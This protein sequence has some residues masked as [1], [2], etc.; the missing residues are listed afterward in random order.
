MKIR[1][2]T[3]I[4]KMMAALLSAVLVVGMVQS[5]APMTALAQ[6][7]VRELN[8]KTAAKETG[9]FVCNLYLNNSAWSGQ[10]VTVQDEEGV[11]TQCIGVGGDVYKVSLPMETKY[12]LYVNGVATGNSFQISKFVGNYQI[13][14][15]LYS[16]SFKDS[17]GAD[18]GIPD[19]IVSRLISPKQPSEPVSKEDGVVFDKWL[20]AD[21]EEFDFASSIEDEIVLYASWKRVSGKGWELDADGKLTIRTHEGMKDWNINGKNIHKDVKSA[22]IQDGVTSISGSAFEDCVNLE[23]IDISGSVI[24]IDENAFEGCSSLGSIK[25]PENLQRIGSYAF[26]E[27]S[28]LQSIEIPENVNLIEN[29]AFANCANLSSVKFIVGNPLKIQ[30]YGIA[31]V[32]ENCK[33]VT[34]NKKGIHVPAGTVHDYQ[35]S[36]VG[37][38]K[39]ITDD[40][41]THDDVTC[42]AWRK[43]DSL[44]TTEGNYY[45]TEDVTLSESW[46][47][48]YGDGEIHLCLNGKTIRLV[49]SENIVRE[50]IHVVNGWTLN[51]H[52]CKGNGK[53]TG[54]TN[55][56]IQNQGIFTMYGGK[57]T[58]NRGS[59]S[60]VYNENV[61]SMY[62]GEISG[63]LSIT[64]N[65]GAVGTSRKK[66]LIVGGSA[67]IAENTN[68]SEE[69]ANLLINTPNKKIL[70]DSA[71]PLSGAAKISIRLYSEEGLISI[72]DANTKDYSRY[73]TS[74]DPDFD[75]VN[76]PDNEVQ[77]I[78][79]H[80]HTLKEH[81]AVPATCTEAGTGAYWKC[82]GED[83]CNQMFSDSTGNNEI[84]EIPEGD[85][86]TGHDYGAWKSNGDG[87]HTRTCANDGAHTE[88]GDCSGGTPTYTEKAV[89][90]VC[91]GSYG[92]VLGDTTPPAGTIRIDDNSWTD[93]LNTITF[94]LFF[95]ETKQVTIEA[96]DR[97]SGVDKIYYHISG[98]NLTEA[99]VKA[100]GGDDW[101]EG[102]S[103]S[104][105]PDRRC[106]IYAKITDKAGN[107]TYLSSDG[108][109]FDG[110]APVIIG[111]TDGETYTSSKVVYVHE[112]NLKSVT[113]NGTEVALHDSAFILK[114]NSGEQTIVATDKAGN[115]TT[116][117]VTMHTHDF[118]EK[119][120]HSKTAHWHE[121]AC[122]QKSDEAAHDFGA[123]ITDKEATESEAGEKHRVCQTCEFEEKETIPAI[124]GGDKPD[125]GKIEQ[126]VQKDDKAPDTKI[127]TPAEKML[128]IVLTPE[129]KEQLSKGTDIKIVL[130][131]KDVSDTVSSGD[132]ALAEAA[133]S[134]DGVA[135]GFAISQYL[136][137]SL[138]KIIGENRSA[139]SETKEKIALALAVP[140]S[141]KNTDSK[142]TRT[143]AVLRI[144]DGK[145]ELLNDVDDNA[146]TITIETDRFATYA[147]V[148]KDVSNGGSGDNNGNDNKDNQDVN[149]KNDNQDNTNNNQNG[150]NDNKDNPD[151]N[152]NDINDNEDDSSDDTDG[153]DDSD[154]SDDS[155]DSSSSG[156]SGSGSSNG[157]GPE[158]GD[159][160]PIE[161]YATLSM[162][163][164][165]TWLLL[166]FSDRKRGMTEETKKRLVSRIVAWAKRGSKIRK[167]PAIAVIVV[168]LV[169]YHSIGKKT[170]V[171]WEEICEE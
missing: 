19:Q 78:R 54:G 170:C 85:D 52:D 39:Y 88:D 147:I 2:G 171:E 57:I 137:I 29:G 16:V 99:G 26:V 59:Y 136:D 79:K 49:T 124:G 36:F 40:T 144:H 129:E 64:V 107:V 51:L 121:C 109:V 84:T 100:L 134:G 10:S 165:F 156:G 118:G 102:D 111:V 90:S 86:A 5:A 143:F 83:G 81:K 62:G 23:E 45:L 159:S 151:D 167:Y 48:F 11:S 68:M 50:V 146:D 127:A 161:F 32:F 130:D 154:S 114:A 35:N 82:E 132:K 149:N 115:T 106:V 93:F 131:V 101:T 153:D 105:N 119:W 140:D 9:E 76:G 3:L 103:F 74:D 142:K 92:E 38:E 67:V 152:K 6:E 104:I 53:I 33:F 46:E 60:G 150:V 69:P 164:G 20:T 75:V 47:P 13:E 166:Y 17:D 37:M 163:A 116:V 169:Y 96:E 77:L 108:L 63:N 98:Y 28:S 89:C 94:G 110:T 125:I 138:F 126:G 25:L 14:L 117:T 123:W 95:R 66:D 112:A 168:L 41:N 97:G 139:I 7:G 141:L 44:P 87:T 65:G 15:N 133:L 21:G 135:K 43:T 71:N 72:T 8:V 4:W 30:F 73:F 91:G 162:I 70:I 128:D 145:A 55:G 148:Y 61:F 80:T 58:G 27:C 12:F 1:R 113:V 157:S 160:A 56:A 155:A 42:T 120:E 18:L 34:G 24:F 22:E 122:G 31:S 158:T